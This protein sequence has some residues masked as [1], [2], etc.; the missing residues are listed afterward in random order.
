MKFKALL[1]IPLLACT[2]ACPTTPIEQNARDTSAALGGLLTEAQAQHQ[3][4]K[5]DA[6]PAVCQTISRAVSGQNTLVTSVEL[7]CG[8]ATSAPP[9]DTSATCVPVKST[10]TA[11]QS[12][13][14]NAQQ[15]INEVK[16]VVKP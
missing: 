7:Y 16:G 5:D 9:P 6:S 13:I 15:L 4:C 14:N 3:E 12:A 8:W 11:L 2:L 1:L 10:A